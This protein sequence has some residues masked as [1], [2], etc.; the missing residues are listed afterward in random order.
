MIWGQLS[1]IIILKCLFLDSKSIQIVTIQ[2]FS[3]FSE[4]D[5]H[6]RLRHFQSIM[7][8][9]ESVQTLSRLWVR[10]YFIL[11]KQGETSK[12]IQGYSSLMSLISRDAFIASNCK[13]WLKI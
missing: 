11:S 6:P 10:N 9:S 13:F 5:P 8:E 7:V 4:N 1:T 3:T 2:L 12:K